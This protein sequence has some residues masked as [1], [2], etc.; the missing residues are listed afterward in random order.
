MRPRPTM[1]TVFS[2]SSMPVYFDRFHS[3]FLQRGVRG[4]D[5]AR[6]GE[7]QRDGQLGGGDDVGGRRVD[8]HD[9]GL[10]G[11]LDVDVVEADAR[12]G[13]DLEPAGCR[14]RLGVD[15]GGGAHQDRVGVGDRRQQLAAVGAV[16]APDLEVGAERL[17]GGGAQL[18]GDEHD[19][20]G[21]G[22]SHSVPLSRVTEGKAR[23]RAG[24]TA[25]DARRCA[26]TT[27]ADH[28]RRPGHVSARREPNPAPTRT[29]VLAPQPPTMQTISP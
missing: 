4:R 29:I 24:R 3:P 20:A 27:L 1:P 11:R 7:H 25:A 8:D 13:D 16:A 9:A 19:G 14:Q 15:L 5:V 22:R 17:D 28:V 21:L 10:G 18:L 12:A 26:R 23:R 6:G 2:Y